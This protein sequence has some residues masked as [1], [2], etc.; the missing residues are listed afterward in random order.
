MPEFKV[1]ASGV[2]GHHKVLRFVVRCTWQVADRIHIDRKSL[3]VAQVAFSDGER[4]VEPA[5]VG[6][7]DDVSAY[8]AQHHVA[9]IQ[10]VIGKT[11]PGIRGEKRLKKGK[12]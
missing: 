12:K 7:V 9:E 11:R 4:A 5:R 2:E 1:G 8:A 10:D 6:G 3:L